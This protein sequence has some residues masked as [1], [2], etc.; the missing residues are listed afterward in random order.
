MPFCVLL[1]FGVFWVPFSEFLVSYV[2]KSEVCKSKQ[3]A[4]EF[5]ISY[6][7]QNAESNQFAIKLSLFWE[8]EIMIFCYVWLEVR[9]EIFRHFGGPEADA[10]DFVDSS[11]FGEAPATKGYSQN[12][13]ILH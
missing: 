12:E 11:D 5:L 3:F 7:C 6:L 13:T 10:K 2:I 8:V 9:I 4:I 1:Y